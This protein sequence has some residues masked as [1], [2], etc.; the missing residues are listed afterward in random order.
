[1]RSDNQ[2]RMYPY[3]AVLLTY[4]L[5]SSIVLFFTNNYLY[6][7][8]VKLVAVSSLLF[9]FRKRFRFKI[10]FDFLA[11]FTGI[12]IF[13]IWIG[14]DNLYPHITLRAPET[15]FT[16]FEII[17]KLLISVAIAP[18]VEEIFTRFFLLRWVIDKN[19][20]KVEQGKYTFSS[21]I[22]TVL[23]FGLSH[24]R[25]LAG[26]ITGVIFNLLYYKTKNIESCILAHA[27]A[28]LA[29]GIFVIYTGSWHFW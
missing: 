11:I 5:T 6:A 8:I 26:M 29:L 22:I 19:W 20:E 2:N 10:K 14:V 24:D 1:M 7:M 23:F 13:G 18:V 16:I 4:L 15:T 9:I 21:F 17:L 3:F 27:I 28:N 25:W 12:L